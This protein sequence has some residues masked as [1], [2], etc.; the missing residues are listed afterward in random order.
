MGVKHARGDSTTV[1]VSQPS[2]IKKHN[3]HMGRVDRSDQYISDHRVLRQTNRYWKTLIYHLIVIAVTNAS[4]C[5]NGTEWQRV[6]EESQRDSSGIILSWKQLWCA[7]AT[8]THWRCPDCPNRPSSCQTIKKDC[9]TLRHSLQ[10]AV[11]RTK[12][13]R[14][15]RSQ[16]PMKRRGRP[17]GRRNKKCRGFVRSN[18]TST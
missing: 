14:Q 10:S 16:L 12:W 4:F 13:F 3:E 5:T 11:T 2:A 17:K 18:N 9:H 7:V 6:A 15:A 1:T 8:Q